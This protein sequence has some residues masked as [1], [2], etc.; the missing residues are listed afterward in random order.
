MNRV[1]DSHIHLYPCEHETPEQFRVKAAEA[2]LAGG[3]IFS[4]PPANSL[5]WKGEAA[6]CWKDRIAIVLDFCSRLEGYH[7]FFWIDPTEPDALEQADYAKNAGIEGFKVLCSRHHPADGIPVYRRAAEYRMPIV[8]HSGILWDGVASSQYNRPGNFECMF[9][10]PYA[11]FALAHF[12]WPWTD[13]CLAVF[14][15]IRNA[16]ELRKD[17]PDMYIDTSWG[18]MDIFREEIYRKAVLLRCG[19]ENK[20]MLAVDSFANNY[21][22]AWAKYTMDFDRR[23]LCETLPAKYGAWQGFVPPGLEGA[24][25]E[26]L[27]PFRKTWENA[28]TKNMTEFLKPW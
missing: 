12:S 25:P 23:L 13:E 8:F 16:H 9:D 3:L 7:P 26:T 11:R 15:K 21:N 6:P 2:G 5:L 14:G 22:T 17:A 27:N 4:H 10:V 18:A 1:F 28:A 24:D 19:I 20:L